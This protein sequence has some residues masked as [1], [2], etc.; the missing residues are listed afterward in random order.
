[1]KVIVVSVFAALILGFGISLA[2][3]VGLLSG[4]ILFHP[5]MLPF[6][7]AGALFSLLVA[8][9]VATGMWEHRLSF[10]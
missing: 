4:A 7:V 5:S 8:G 10:V 6:A 9:V 1:M 3:G 2:V